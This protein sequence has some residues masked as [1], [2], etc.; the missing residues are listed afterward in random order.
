MTV[1]ATELRGNLY[2]I[3]DQ[4]LETGEPVD[5]VRGGRVIR[6]VPDQVRFRAADVKPHPEYVAGD[7]DDLIH[8][9]WSGEWTP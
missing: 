9:D 1:T 3:L 5:I 6:L 7:P 8:H 2:R 4:I